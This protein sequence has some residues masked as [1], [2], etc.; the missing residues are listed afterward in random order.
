MS[1]I[2]PDVILAAQEAQDKYYV[3]SSVSIAQWALESGYG[4]H[5]PTGSNNPFGI[6]AKAGEA[7]VSATTHEVV[8]GVTE[9]V[10]QNFAKYGSIAEAFDAHAK[11]LATVSLYKDA[12]T[13]WVHAKDLN[14]GII[15]MAKH[16]ATD[17][18]YATKVMAIITANKLVQYDARSTTDSPPSTVVVP[19]TPTAQ[20]TT[21]NP[22]SAITLVISIAQTFAPL[23]PELISD[24]ELFVADT[25][26]LISDL[27]KMD[28]SSTIADV[29][30]LF[31]DVETDM[32]T[33][34]KIVTAS[35]GLAI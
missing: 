7:F 22:I 23:F 28:S 27:K 2:P 11:L 3:P 34:A 26:K 12:M 9:T 13:A 6:K 33:I 16:Y 4:I 14:L 8:N 19:P 29:Q 31:N 17:P 35:K 21:M 24:V 32:A 25:T 20:V 1:T 10:S 18:S 15:Y 30:K 5:M